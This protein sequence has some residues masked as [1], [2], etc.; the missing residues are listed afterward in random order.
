MR[1]VAGVGLA[2]LLVGLRCGIGS[3]RVLAPLNDP[4]WLRLA[5]G[6]NGRETIAYPPCPW[7]VYPLLGFAAGQTLATRAES[8]RGD[9][10]PDRWR[11]RRSE[12]ASV[13]R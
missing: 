9:A 10:L 1:Q 11:S 13:G 8:A 4:G 12:P 5:V 7:L 6:T 2:A 3:A